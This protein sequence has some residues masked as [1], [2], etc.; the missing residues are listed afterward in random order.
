MKRNKLAAALL[1][2]LLFLCGI[3]VGALGQRFYDN[4]V[5]IA[6]PTAENFRRH[7]LEEMRS[8]LKLTPAQERQLE[9]ILDDTKAKYKA[10]RDQFHPQMLAIKNEQISRVKA[11]LTAQQIPEYD[12]IVAEHERRAHEMEAHDHPPDRQH[13]PPPSTGR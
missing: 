3:A 7:Y 4:R 5:V 9:A 6:G 12:R 8:R 11:I 2:V 1:S 13:E 10:V